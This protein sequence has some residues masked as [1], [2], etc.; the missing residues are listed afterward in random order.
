MS[1]K[2]MELHELT[3][4]AHCGEAL[5]FEKGYGPEFGLCSSC[6]ETVA[7]LYWLVHA[8][9]PLTWPRDKRPAAPVKIP[10][11]EKWFILRRDDFKC[12]ACWAEDR[13]LHVDHI[14]ARANG[15]SNDESNLQALCDK[16]NLRKGAK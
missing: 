5:C 7:N 1:I 16:C 14:V 10:P 9:E 4:C 11:K 2:I 15:G 6:A 13:P 3:P 12:Q 8:G